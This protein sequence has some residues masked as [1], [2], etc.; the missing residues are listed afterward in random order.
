MKRFFVEKLTRPLF[1][2]EGAEN[3]HLAEVL[4]AKK[5]DRVL[6]CTGDGFDYEYEIVGFSRSSTTLEYKSE[7]LNTSEPELFL[8]VY[9]SMLKGDKSELVVQKLTELGVKRIVPFISEFSVSRPDK[10]DRLARAA[11]EACKQCGRAVIPE[12]SGILSFKE[13]LDSLDKHEKTVFAY[14]DI[15]KS[16]KTISDYLS[17]SEKDVALI[18]GPE[19]GFSEKEYRAIAFEKSIEPVS[20][21]RRILRAET[22]AIAATAVILSL[23]GEW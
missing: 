9:F 18:I 8:T 3:K 6:L 7:R 20:L 15:S 12:V 22:A 4:R 21:G 17:G 2:L 14:E 23:E 13:M 16:S 19:G 10:T 5:G 1:V 11:L